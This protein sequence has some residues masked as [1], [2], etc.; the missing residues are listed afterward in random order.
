MSTVG[1][2]KLQHV[3]KNINVHAHVRCSALAQAYVCAQEISEKALS[4]HR[5]LTLS[6]CTRG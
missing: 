3:P 6:F 2:A 5:W 4:S 1:F